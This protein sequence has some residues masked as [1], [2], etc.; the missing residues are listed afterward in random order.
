MP[1]L[2]YAAKGQILIKLARQ[3]IRF[4][5]L[6]FTCSHTKLH[7]ADFSSILLLFSIMDI[8][9]LINACSQIFSVYVL[10]WTK[11]FEMYTGLVETKQFV[12]FSPSFIRYWRMQ[13]RS[14]RGTLCEHCGV[15]L[16]PV[17]AR[18]SSAGRCL[19]G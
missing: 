12:I 7:Y 11:H 19:C 8:N 2:N 15:F 1:V 13:N 9:V 5:I 4:L 18:I 14:M 17:W 10:I 6:H 16:L 3:K